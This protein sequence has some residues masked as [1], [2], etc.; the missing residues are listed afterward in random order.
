V[1]EAASLINAFP[2]TATQPI[3]KW[4]ERAG[5]APAASQFYRAYLFREALTWIPSIIGGLLVWPVALMG[6]VLMSRSQT[7]RAFLLFHPLGR[8]LGGMGQ[9]KAL[10]FSVPAL[11][12]RFFRP[13]RASMLGDMAQEDSE[14]EG[15]NY[16]SASGAVELRRGGVAQQ[17]RDL[18][19]LTLMSNSTVAPSIIERL[20]RWDGRVFLI[21]PS[22]R[23]K[24]M[25]LKH[26]I[27]V[28]GHV[29]EP[30]IFATAAALGRDPIKA[31]T[32][33]FGGAIPD[34][35][36]LDSLIQSKRLDLYVDGL[37]EV[38]PETRASI[39]DF[40]SSRPSANIFTTTQPLERYPSE[41][42]L[43]A[44]LPLT[45]PQISTFLTSRHHA[46]NG[47]QGSGA[48]NYRV[49]TLAFVAEK[50]SEAD[51]EVATDDMESSE[52][53]RALVERLSNPMDLQT[54]ADL[55]IRG[56]RPDVW[57]LQKQR[58]ALVDSSYR[59]QTS[60]EPFPLEVFSRYVYES[61]RDGKPEIDESRFPRVAEIL[62][63]EK[64]IQRYI[65]A[66]SGFKSD[67]Y[68]FRHDKIRDFYT[69]PAFLADSDLRVA[70][71]GDDKFSGVYDLLTQ[72][73]LPQDATDLREFLAERAL[74]RGDHRLSDRYLE[75]LRTRRALDSKDPPWLAQHDRSD[76]TNDTAT[77]LALEVERSRIAVELAGVIQRLDVG[78]VGTRVISA[79][80][81]DNLLN[82][83][84]ALFL[85]IG[86]VPV[87]VGVAQKALFQTSNHFKF[88][89][90]GFAHHV[91]LPQRILEASEALIR[92]MP[93]DEVPT[94]VVVN[95]Q[96]DLA[97]SLRS[98]LS[99]S[100]IRAIFRGERIVVYSA[101]D[102]LKIIRAKDG[103]YAHDFMVLWKEHCEG[104]AA[105]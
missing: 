12:R 86:I 11:R 48:E 101:W 30:S 46:V 47:E 36:F 57:G 99:I 75:G 51:A 70:H 29:R 72:E 58:H 28:S 14:L 93:T 31:L 95:A 87:G 66:D 39:L 25:F 74:D 1:T 83:L 85:E 56:Q 45:R 4:M 82:A 67:G 16:F 50:L 24:S 20:S 68:I 90:I 103:V 41:A 19:R 53:S 63:K 32:A 54:I 100:A 42:K 27:L 55:L 38:D 80:R 7:L 73:L 23:G 21:G 44:L 13:Y 17:L 91:E 49:Q 33:R 98:H 65:A 15:G 96:A 5:S 18:D 8:Q 84:T 94:L 92:L 3:A 52:R 81:P 34:D 76:V 62:L 22:G 9:T 64:Q 10:I 97:P 60:N 78:R 35:Q 79:A 71:A 26:H 43:F 69:Y 77:I 59:A 89:V 88:G 2:L 105:N 37:N 40:I 102:L 6:L 61:R 104:M